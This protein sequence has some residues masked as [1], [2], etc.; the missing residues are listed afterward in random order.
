MKKE[1]V[2]RAIVKLMVETSESEERRKRVRELAEIAK[3]AV[4]E[5]G[6]NVTFLVQVIMQKTKADI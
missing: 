1:D 4:E 5:G 6:S 3:K 2:E